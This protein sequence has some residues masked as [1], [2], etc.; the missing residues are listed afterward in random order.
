MDSLS[1]ADIT[2]ILQLAGLTIAVL[3]VLLILFRLII[4]FLRLL[5]RKKMS[6]SNTDLIGQ[7]ATV[8][9]T[10]R[11]Q[12]PGEIECEWRGQLLTGPAISEATIRPGKQVLIYAAEKDYY[13]VRLI[14][15][16]Y[17]E[18]KYETIESKPQS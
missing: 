15:Y 9:R 14:E 12:R 6:S 5:L 13:K 1:V 17:I 8:R 4:L 16:D 11:S 7:Q 18:G 3:A 2:R 10:V